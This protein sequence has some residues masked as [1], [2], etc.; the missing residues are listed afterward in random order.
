MVSGM[1]SGLMNGKRWVWDSSVCPGD[2]KYLRQLDDA[3]IFLNKM[4]KTHNFRV[5]RG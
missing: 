5:S 2:E 4:E 3:N 1:A